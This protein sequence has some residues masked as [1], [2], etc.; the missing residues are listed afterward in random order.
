MSRYGS[1][2]VAWSV[3]R[4]SDQS[5]GTAVL[6]P[7]TAYTKATVHNVYRNVKEWSPLTESHRRNDNNTSMTIPQ[8]LQVTMRGISN[9]LL[10]PPKNACTLSDPFAAAGPC[11]GSAKRPVPISRVEPPASRLKTFPE[12]VMPATVAL[13]VVLSTMTK[14]DCTLTSNPLMLASGEL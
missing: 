13:N 11:V 7:R 6:C 8:T 1:G 10:C 5:Q 3:A 9:L 4:K 12:M 2:E 14:E